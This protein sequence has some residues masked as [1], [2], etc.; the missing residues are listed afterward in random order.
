[1]AYRCYVCSKG[2]ATGKSVSH[3]HRK[4]NRR[5]SPNL[6]KIKILSSS[7]ISREYVCTTCIKSNKVRK[8][9]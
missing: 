1:M 3:S 6:Q 7:G 5:F 2:V 9:A 4:T 8:A